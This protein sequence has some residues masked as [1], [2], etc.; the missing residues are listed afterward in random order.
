MAVIVHA[1]TFSIGTKGRNQHN[2]AIKISNGLIRNGHLVLNFSDRDVARASSLIGHRKFG[3]GAVNRTLVEFCRDHQPALLLLGHADMIDAATVTELRAVVPGIVVLQWYVDALFVPEHIPRFEAKADVV[4]ATLIS[5]GVAALEPLRRGRRRV[6]FLPNPVDVSI[7]RGENHLRRDLPY[8]LFFAVGDPIRTVCGRER[9]MDEFMTALLKEVPGARPLVAG[10]H[11][12]PYLHGAAYQA[13][14]ES[15]AIGLNISRRADWPLY[16]SDRLAQM[17]GNG[18]AVAMERSTGYDALFGEDEMLFFS[19]F[20]ELA[21]R[22]RDAVAHPERRQ[23][24]AA[25]GRESYLRL[26]NERTVARYILDFAFDR[27]DAA[28]YGWPPGLI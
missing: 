8:D 11:G 7:E 25:K 19:S 22:L 23:A 16:S 17:I 3:R 6:G 20:E 10:L 12:R 14:L 27:A 1:S 9:H 21:A 2:T 13:A 18:M 24:L 28:S 4:D 5:T 15:A 26:F